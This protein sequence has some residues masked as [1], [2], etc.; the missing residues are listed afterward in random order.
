MKIITPGNQY[1]WQ[2]IICHCEGEDGCQTE[3]EIEVGDLYRVFSY[4][5]GN[6]LVTEYGVKCP[7][8]K[9]ETLV[10][11]NLPVQ[12]ELDC[13]PERISH[14]DWAWEYEYLK[15]VTDSMKGSVHH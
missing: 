7:I 4:D 8:C 2:R 12:S 15:T 11:Q 6:T 3:L 14:P 5:S 10:S 9:G 13:V 1:W